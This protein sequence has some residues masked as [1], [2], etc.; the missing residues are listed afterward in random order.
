VIPRGRFL[1]L[2]WLALPGALAGQLSPIQLEVNVGAAVPVQEF[3]GPEGFEGEV[4][5]GASFGVHFV[6]GQRRLSW[7]VGF[8]EHRFGCSA[9]A[10]VNAEEIVSTGWDVGVRLNVLRGPVVPWVQAGLAAYVSRGQF[11]PGFGAI[12]PPGPLVSESDRGWGFE[13]GAGVLISVA[14]RFAL[15]P[16]VRYTSV[17]PT[18]AG[19]NFGPLNSKFVVVDVG[20]VLVF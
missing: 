1:A 3:S 5:T 6:V 12:A 15:N 13:A 14:P 16:G 9:D 19:R 10:C 20:L 7:Y 2:L 18:F 8:S 4:E 17:D 11:V